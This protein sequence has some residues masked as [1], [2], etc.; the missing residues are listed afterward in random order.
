MSH[1][2]SKNAA[3]EVEMFCAGKP[4]WHGLGI[5][6]QDAQTWEN[7]S[8]LAKLDWTIS[9]VQLT[10]PRTSA[11][12]PSYALLRDDDN[13]WISTVGDKYT[14]IQNAQAFSFV[15]ALL[16]AGKAHYESAGALGNGEVMWCMARLNAQSFSPVKGDEHQTYLLFSEF[17]DGRAAQVRL[18]L[19]R[20][21]CQNTLNIALG[22]KAVN[23]AVLKLRHTSGIDEKI[24]A[25]KDLLTTVG[26]EISSI[27]TKFQ[28]LAT[29]KITQPQF[30]TIM[31]KLFPGF[32]KSSRSENKAAMVASNFM[33]NDGGQIKGIEG[34]AYALLQGVTRW[35]DHQ[36]DGLR[37]GD[38][39]I[40]AKRAESAMFG[41]GDQFKTFALDTIS[42]VVGVDDI[43]KML[44]EV[45]L[46]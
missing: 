31:E 12:I 20:V 38:S 17:R 11:G 1:N 6:V 18:T 9:K 5:N 32:E 43:D 34:S 41:S 23:G 30:F 8:K 46:A 10:N 40:E 24:K 19:T 28:A 37:V 42:S 2:L 25:A 29:K 35:I 36:R 21:V 27:K 33:A 4:A 3:G 7:A 13:R 15:D 26:S 14:P 22:S 16:E 39:S 45:A 44:A